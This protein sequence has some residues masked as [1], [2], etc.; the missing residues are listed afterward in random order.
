MF[1]WPTT[2]DI[3]QMDL[4]EKIKLN[5]FGFKANTNLYQFKLRYSN[6]MESD[7]MNSMEGATLDAKVHDIVP[8]KTIQT[9][10]IL[11][12]SDQNNIYGIRFLDD[13]GHKI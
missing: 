12:R 9:V 5:G 1:Q 6:G 3:E 7:T 11:L 8:S 10:E 2:R 13:R 4:D